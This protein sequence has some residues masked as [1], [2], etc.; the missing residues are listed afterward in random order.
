M[1]NRSTVGFCSSISRISNPS[2]FFN[3]FSRVI[4][5]DKLVLFEI[6]DDAAT[7]LPE[8]KTQ[9]TGLE[10]PPDRAEPELG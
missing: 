4:A 1:T 3:S 7:A 9:A 6:Y 10:D 8:G 5:V 2:A